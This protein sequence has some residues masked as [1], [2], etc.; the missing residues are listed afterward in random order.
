MTL[1]RRGRSVFRRT[2]VRGLVVM[3]V[4]GEHLPTTAQWTAHHF[5]TFATPPAIS[6]EPP[7]MPRLPDRSTINDA[8]RVARRRASPAKSDSS[9]C[10]RPGTPNSAEAESPAG[11]SR[12]IFTGDA[13]AGVVG[14]QRGC[15]QAEHRARRDVDGDRI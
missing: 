12:R 7:L 1:C 13:L 11:S 10:A 4:I 6:G 15:D 8:N 2:L 5:R 9:D 14:H 3:S